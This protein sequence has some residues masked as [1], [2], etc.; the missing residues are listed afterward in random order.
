MKQ[1]DQFVVPKQGEGVMQRGG[2]N[3]LTSV[4]SLWPLVVNS[5]PFRIWYLVDQ[6]RD[7]GDMTVYMSRRQT[8]S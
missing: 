8:A 2:W 7:T 4:P 5:S 6:L 3:N 1:K